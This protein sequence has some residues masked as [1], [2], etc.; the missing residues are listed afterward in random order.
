ME[1]GD[2]KLLKEIISRVL[3][4]G[5]RCDR[6]LYCVIVKDT[7]MHYEEYDDALE[8]FNLLWMMIEYD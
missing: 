5:C 1:F 4:A 7:T 2:T 6:V 8:K 3:V